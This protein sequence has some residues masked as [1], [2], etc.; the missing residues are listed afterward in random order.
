MA[1]VNL[2][3]LKPTRDS[4]PPGFG[5]LVPA[6][7]AQTVLGCT[8]SHLKFPGRVPAG[9]YLL[10]IFVGG[11]LHPEVVEQEDS[12]LVK[13]VCQE[14]RQHLGFDSAPDLVWIRRYR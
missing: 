9:A 4:L 2:G 11:P 14:I 8:F 1:V 5:Y 10:R 7:E 12:T 3:F 13:K 6:R